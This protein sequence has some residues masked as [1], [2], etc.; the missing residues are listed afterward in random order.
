MIQSGL[1]LNSEYHSVINFVAAPRYMKPTIVMLIKSVILTGVIIAIVLVY[2]KQYI[3]S[4]FCWS[5]FA[6][7]L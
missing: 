4:K 5:H 6:E 1:N 3:K 7:K 2:K